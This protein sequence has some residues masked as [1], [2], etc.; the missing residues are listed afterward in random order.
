MFGVEIGAV[1]PQTTK[2]RALQF[3]HDYDEVLKLKVGYL[4]PPFSWCPCTQTLGSALYGPNHS[5][6]SGF[7]LSTVYGFLG[8]S[9]RAPT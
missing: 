6:L 3:S 2:M 4:K 9:F 7:K 1:M 5:L 8:A